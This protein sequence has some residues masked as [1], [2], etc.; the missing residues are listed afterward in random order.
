MTAA[1]RPSLREFLR[2]PCDAPNWLFMALSLLV[3]I[4]GLFDLLGVGR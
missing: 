4:L 3:I 1:K 2:E